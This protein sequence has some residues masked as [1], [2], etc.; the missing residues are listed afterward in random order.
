MRRVWSLL[1]IAAAVLGVVV[2]VPFSGSA[3]TVTPSGPAFTVP[4]VSTPQLTVPSVSTP[5]ASTPAVTVPSVSTPS[6]TPS[7]PS[8]SGAVGSV[9]TTV[10][11]AARA[12]TGGAGSG[13]GSGTPSSSG[14]AAG[15]SSAG[16]S[17]PSP[18]V[19]SSAP[20]AAAGQAPGTGPAASEGI[21]RHHRTAAQRS[22]AQAAAESRRLR[23]LVTTLDACLGGLSPTSSRLLTLRAGIGT[24]SARSGAAVAKL[25]HVTPARERT[26]ERTAVVALVRAATE[27]CAG[28]AGRATARSAQTQLTVSQS[29]SW[30]TASGS[31]S[32]P[33]YD[34]GKVSAAA[35]SRRPGHRS[36]VVLSPAATRTVEGAGAGDGGVP[37]IAIAAFAALL[38]GLS[39]IALPGLRRRVLP[40]GTAG[41][42]SADASVPTDA[43]PTAADSAPP[44]AA[45]VAA[46]ATAERPRS[47]PVDTPPRVGDDRPPAAAAPE[48]PPAAAKPPAEPALDAPPAAAPASSAPPRA[49]APAPSPARTPAAAPRGA[50]AKE[51][52]TQA[53]L[54]AG[55]LAG[56]LARLLTGRRHRPR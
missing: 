18:A 22:A 25:L 10:T 14:S 13:G 17:A 6:T 15:G 20:S 40:A 5:V 30:P 7:T 1:V 27:G 11:S 32:P 45:M 54:V 50:W 55:V 37:G 2:A 21:T 19:G 48:L 52:A 36:V 43:A 47:K 31:S 33:H 28:T 9:V 42:L 16:S 8:P 51:H 49:A 3:A 44:A 34:P 4:S 23:R 35:R 26:L 29:G 12:V 38:M 53:G 46:A 41:S 39:L 24:A 56:G